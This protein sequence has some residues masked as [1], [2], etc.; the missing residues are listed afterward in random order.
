MTIADDVSSARR[1]H[2]GR[3][4][5]EIVVDL[6]LD[7]RRQ[8]LLRAVAQHVGQD[9]SRRLSWELDQF[10]VRASSWWRTSLPLWGD[11]G[12]LATP[13]VRRLLTASHTTFGY[14]SEVS[15]LL[16]FQV[17][18]VLCL[19]QCPKVACEREHAPLAILG[20]ALSG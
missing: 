11:L 10:F 2:S 8:H 12:A 9:V 7:R 1:V 14:I 18:A 4:T 6:G 3:S 15:G 16:Q 5:R 17:F 19:Q 13:R 20:R